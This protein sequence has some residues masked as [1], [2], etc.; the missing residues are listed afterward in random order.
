MRPSTL[1]LLSRLRFR[2]PFQAISA[3]EENSLG[4]ID[5][6]AATKPCMG[7]ASICTALALFSDATAAAAGLITEHQSAGCCAFALDESYEKS[8]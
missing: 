3:P 6:S 1:I 7:D 4:Q 2:K 5:A 8:S